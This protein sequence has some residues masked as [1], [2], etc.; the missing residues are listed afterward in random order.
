MINKNKYYINPFSQKLQIQNECI[1]QVS[2]LYNNNYC[3]A[4]L[5]Y[6]Q[7]ISYFKTKIG[8]GSFPKL[9]KVSKYFRDSRK[10]RRGL[11]NAY[12]N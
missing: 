11:P 12:T 9:F 2:L 3:K 5:N 10:T 1:N 6:F 4:M 7:T 8:I